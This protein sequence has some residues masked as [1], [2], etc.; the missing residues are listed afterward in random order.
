MAIFRL[1]FKISYLC[2]FKGNSVPLDEIPK[3]RRE[4]LPRRAPD[5]SGG[6]RTVPRLDLGRMVLPLAGSAAQNGTPAFP[7]A[8]RSPQLPARRVREAFA[9]K[10]ELQHR[11][12]VL[13]LLLT[14]VGFSSRGVSSLHQS[15]WLA[16]SRALRAT[17][18]AESHGLRALTKPEAEKC[19][20][21]VRGPGL[22][23]FSL[24]ATQKSLR[25]PPAE[26]CLSVLCS[27]PPQL[28]PD[29][30]SAALKKYVQANTKGFFTAKTR[31]S[32]IFIVN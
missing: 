2:G 9:G 23:R 5:T 26:V 12:P 8:R 15:R 7:P 21:P 24:S 11:G 14:L 28:C 19:C 25:E 31:M 29:L 20:H 22:C 17:P 3:G 30:P 18:A 6:W 4:F 16:S 32:W 13:A 1:F 27:P 10:A